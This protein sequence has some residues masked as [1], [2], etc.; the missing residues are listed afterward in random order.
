MPGFEIAQGGDHLGGFS[1]R[2]RK[3]SFFEKED[4][5]RALRAVGQPLREA[6]LFWFGDIGFA[7]INVFCFFFQ[8]RRPLFFLLGV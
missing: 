4:F 6:P 1:G 7:R 5:R 3:K 2:I 8:K